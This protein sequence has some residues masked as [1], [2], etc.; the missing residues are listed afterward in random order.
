MPLSDG[1]CTKRIGASA[2]YSMEEKK[3]MITYT[4]SKCGFVFKKD[5]SVKDVMCTACGHIMEME[6]DSCVP[7]GSFRYKGKWYRDDKRN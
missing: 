7:K 2:Y 3:G 6:K 5:E 1:H 4:C